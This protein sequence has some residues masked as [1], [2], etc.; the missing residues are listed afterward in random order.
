MVYGQLPNKFGRNSGSIIAE[1]AAEG[2]HW[3]VKLLQDDQ[4]PSG[5]RLAHFESPVHKS[6]AWTEFK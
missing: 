1:V 5:A 4:R 2:P 6:T 3:E